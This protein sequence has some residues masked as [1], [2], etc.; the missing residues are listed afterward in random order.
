VERLRSLT[1]E[2]C[3]LRCYGSAL[4]G[5]ALYGRALYGRRGSDD[6]VRLL[7]SRTTPRLDLRLQQSESG[8]R[9]RRLLE[10]RMDARESFEAA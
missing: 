4:Y 7:P 6:P 9:L 1:E 3:Y 8:E 2:E 10:L 5:R